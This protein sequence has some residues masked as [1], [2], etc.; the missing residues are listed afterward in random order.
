MRQVNSSAR[1]CVFKYLQWEWWHRGVSWWFRWWR[2]SLRWGKPRFDPWVRKIS[3]RRKWQPTPVLL[4]GE[5]HW[6]RSLAGYSPWGHKESNATKKLTLSLSLQ[7]LWSWQ[8]IRKVSVKHSKQDQ[9]HSW[10]SLNEQLFSALKTAEYWHKL[11]LRMSFT[12]RWHH[13]HNGHEFEQ[14]PGDGERQGS[15]ECCSPRGRNESDTT[16]QLNNI[17]RREFI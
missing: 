14:T 1:D 16:D 13:R 11:I 8:K 7:V 12:V 3:W 9:G 15:L 6:Q 2:I 5:F 4:P 10:E 17:L